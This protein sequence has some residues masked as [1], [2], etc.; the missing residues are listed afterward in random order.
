[1]RQE[2][3]LPFGI[4]IEHLLHYLLNLFWSLQNEMNWRLGEFNNTF[5]SYEF[6]I[7]KV[8]PVTAWKVS[9]YGDFLVCISS[10]LDTVHVVCGFD[11]SAKQI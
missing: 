3:A 8:H 9:K 2:L 7:S 4:L 6:W 10:H 1:M 11:S 5:C